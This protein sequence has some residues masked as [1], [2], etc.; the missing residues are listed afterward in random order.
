MVIIIIKHGNISR[1]KISKH[2]GIM[3][4]TLMRPDGQSIDTVLSKRILYTLSMPSWSRIREAVILKNGSL[5]QQSSRG[6]TPTSIRLGRLGEL[7]CCP[8]LL[9]LHYF[10]VHFLFLQSFSIFN[11]YK[12]VTFF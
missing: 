1:R 10:L 8:S 12:H 9:F 11:V 2:T 3:D 4:A 6:M 7:S 5:H